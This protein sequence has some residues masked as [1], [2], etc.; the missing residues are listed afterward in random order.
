VLG[1]LQAVGVSGRGTLDPKSAIE[2]AVSPDG[3]YAFVSLE[4]AGVIAVFDLQRARATGWRRSGFVGA[5]PVGLV[6]VGLAMSPDGR[7]LYATRAVRRGGE[8]QA[9]PGTLDVIDVAR[10]EQ[11][12]QT[13]V[14]AHVEAGCDPV[15]V[16]ATPDGNTVWVTARA[17]DALLGFSAARLAEAPSR[18]LERVVRV[19]EAPVG[20]ALID[21]GRRIVVMN[22]DRFGEPGVEA[23]LGVVDGNRG[24]LLGT[25][26]S[27]D[28][29]REAA[30]V[31]GGSELLVSNWGSRELEAVELRGLP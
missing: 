6:V 31:S 2:V 12:P 30:V 4:Y 28:F 24:K 20:L 22:S 8:V 19:G 26:A 17:S 25:I 29:P 5:I 23:A 10:A 18:A 15:R 13:A 7:T 1:S 16:A 3:N 21:G 27:G 14:V 11:H 9:R